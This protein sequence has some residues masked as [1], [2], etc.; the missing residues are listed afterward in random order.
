M[1]AT[2][3][4]HSAR[5]GA[6]G[7]CT[8][9]S[10]HRMAAGILFTSL[11]TFQ[12][13][14]ADKHDKNQPFMRGASDESRI[15]RQVRHELLMLPYYGVFDD[16]KFKV[17]GYT[18][19]LLSAVTRP[20]LKSDAEAVVKRVEGVEKVINQIEVLPLSP[21]DDRIRIAEFKAIYG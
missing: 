1:L 8:K 3:V 15:A 11:L 18:V 19:T 7:M 9:R 21:M 17:E 16:L 4:H 13:A 5:K 10:A 6:T 14:A 2:K 20:T 12:A